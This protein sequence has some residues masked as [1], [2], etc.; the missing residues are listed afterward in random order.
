MHSI[1]NCG[2]KW[3]FVVKE[4]AFRFTSDHGPE[5]IYKPIGIMHGSI[6]VKDPTDENYKSFQTKDFRIDTR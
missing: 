3:E 4:E 5:Y 6:H 1:C 2:F